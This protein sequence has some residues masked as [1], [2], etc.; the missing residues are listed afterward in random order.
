[1]FQV[2]KQGAIGFSDEHIAQASRSASQVDVNGSLITLWPGTDY[3][4]FEESLFASLQTRESESIYEPQGCKHSKRVRNYTNTCVHIGNMYGCMCKTKH[5]ATSRSWYAFYKCDILLLSYFLRF[6]LF[7]GKAQLQRERKSQR[8]ICWFTPQLATVNR[9]KS[10]AGN[11][12][13]VSHKGTGG[14]RI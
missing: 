8:E 4:V 5:R 10:E 6:I 14:I 3:S 12:P 13:W 1:M 2:L 11:L 7:I 9:L